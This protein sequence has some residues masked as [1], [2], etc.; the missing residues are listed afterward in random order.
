MWSA[1]GDIIGPSFIPFVCNNDTNQLQ[2]SLSLQM[3]ADDTNILYSD[4]D[5]NKIHNV[6]NDNLKKV[7]HWFKCNKLSVNSKKC[8]Y[9]VFRSSS[10]RLELEELYVRLNEDVIPRVDCTKFLG[11]LIIYEQ[12]IWKPHDILPIF[13][14][15]LPRT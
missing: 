4:K 10:R 15:R 5:L 3:Y 2:C 6:V 13:R 14:I 7:C 9:I 11:E 12:L 8:N 1:S